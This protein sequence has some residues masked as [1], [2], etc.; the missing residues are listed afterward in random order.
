MW[1]EWLKGRNNPIRL[2]SQVNVKV[3]MLKLNESGASLMSYE[4][5]KSS[6]HRSYFHW[7][8]GGRTQGG[9]FIKIFAKW[10]QQQH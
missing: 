6:P 9:G 2:E 1:L 10:Q 4:L 3:G 8:W 5:L 7:A